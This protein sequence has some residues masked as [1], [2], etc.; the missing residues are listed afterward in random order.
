MTRRR[1]FG[2]AALLVC[3]VLG[4]SVLDSFLYDRTLDRRLDALAADPLANQ[5]PVGVTHV[6]RF[7]DR[8]D[9]L[10]RSERSAPYLLIRYLAPDASQAARAQVEAAR[11][12]GWSPGVMICGFGVTQIAVGK[13]LAKFDAEATIRAPSRRDG[14]PRVV[15]VELVAP[16]PG[17][18]NDRASPSAHPAGPPQMD[19]LDGP[20]R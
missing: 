19:C 5:L 3:V 2:I 9:G 10:V 7:R 4:Y 1:G 18:D 8:G 16:R 17:N 15:T 11:A 12:A 14:D 20:S 13:R 6:E